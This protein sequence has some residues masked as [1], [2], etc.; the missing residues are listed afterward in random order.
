MAKN[1]STLKTS[2]LGFC[3]MIE[4]QQQKMFF[5]WS[6]FFLP[7]IPSILVGDASFSK[8]LV[9]NILFAMDFKCVILDLIVTQ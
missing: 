7:N 6:I 4:P 5:Q 1:C 3:L 9:N 8:S 2:N